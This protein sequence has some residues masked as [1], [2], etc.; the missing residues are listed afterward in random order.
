MDLD[1]FLALTALSELQKERTTNL[2]NENRLR[3]EN[4]QIKEKASNAEAVLRIK[5]GFTQ[6][7]LNKAKQMMEALNQRNVAVGSE[8]VSMRNKVEYYEDLLTY[9]MPTIANNN[10]DFKKTLSN[11]RDI[12]GRWMVEHKGFQEVATQ[13]GVKLGYSKEE[14]NEL[15]KKTGLQIAEKESLDGTH[16]SEYDPLN[17]D[18][19]KRIKDR[20][21]S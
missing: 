21:F 8:L 10:T 3:E 2:A 13:F 6:G 12:L 14:I 4:S 20:F 16:N 15:A 11:Q 18:R 1:D 9:N 19:I 5:Q 7:E 17:P